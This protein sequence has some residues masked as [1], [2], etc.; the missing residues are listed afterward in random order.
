[1]VRN[2]VTSKGW[3]RSWRA[4]GR[5]FRISC[6]VKSKCDSYLG[7]SSVSVNYFVF[8]V[9][10]WCN[11]YFTFSAR[12]LIFRESFQFL[13]QKLFSN[14]TCF[15]KLHCRKKSQRMENEN[16]C[17][18]L[19]CFSRLIFLPTT[20]KTLWRVICLCSTRCSYCAVKIC[21]GFLFQHVL[22]W[23]PT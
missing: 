23:S 19:A 16:F 9:I 8:P 3:W 12:K 7:C 21:V 5:H 10:K 13:F 17:L 20:L 22:S 11:K 18:F 14:P 2:A 6:S 4:I 15:I 1:M